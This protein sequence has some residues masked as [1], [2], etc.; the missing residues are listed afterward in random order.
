MLMKL[1]MT[2]FQAVGANLVEG[3]I[4]DLAH[5]KLPTSTETDTEIAPLIQNVGATSI[6][7][8]DRLLAELQLA[9][10]FL[11]SEGER[12]EQEMVRFANLA[13]IWLRSPPRSSWTPCANGTPRATNKTQEL[14]K[15]RRLRPTTASP[16][17]SL[18]RHGVS[19]RLRFRRLAGA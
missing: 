8:I 16:S 7:E 2:N 13:Q 9:R 19:R 11:Q 18:R 3:D 15:P 17:N 10:E 6:E 4:Y 12:V 5:A 14:P 1:E